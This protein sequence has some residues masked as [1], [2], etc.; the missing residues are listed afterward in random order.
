MEEMAPII[1]VPVMMLVTGWI[2]K[3]VGQN[4]RLN[5]LAAMNAELQAKVLDKLGSAQDIIAYLGTE[6]GSRLLD[7][8]VMERE[9]PYS[10]ILSSVQAG[11]VLALVGI[12]VLVVRSMSPGL[13]Q[14]G[15]AFLGVIALALGVGFVLSAVAAHAL[16]KSYGLING[17]GAGSEI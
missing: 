11:I 14:N 15:M 7:A 8:P 5:K 17:R 10:R 12:A 2:V 9:G 3:M 4:R 16:S 6:A 13:D 1:V